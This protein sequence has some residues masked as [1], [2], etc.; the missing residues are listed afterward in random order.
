[1]IDSLLERANQL[2]KLKRYQDAV[3]ELKQVLSIEPNRAQALALL[4]I[5][6]A[7]QNNTREAINFIQQAV[8][9]EPDNDFFLYLYAFF[10]FKEDKL[11][12]SEK[13]IRNAIAFEPRNAEYFGLLAL[14][15]IN[16]KEWQ[17]ALD[18]ANQGLAVDP[19]NLTCLNARSTAFFK[20]DKKEEAYSTINEALSKD[21]YNEVTHT[22][23]GWGLLEKGDHKKALEHFREALKINPDFEYAKA[24]LVEGLKARYWFYRMFLKYAFWVGNMKGKGQWAV[25]IG[26][27]FGARILRGV[28]ENNAT[29]ALFITPVIYLYI[30][31]AISTWIIGPLSNLFLRLNV[32]GRFALTDEETQSSNFVG[33]SL[34]VGGFGG[35]LFLFTND[36]LYAMLL[37]YGLTMMIPLAS[38]FNPAKERSKQILVG[39]TI[40]IGLIGLG[41]IM[42]QAFSY[43]VGILGTIYIFGILAYQWIANAMIIR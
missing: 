5:C 40:L 8:S 30:L 4:S 9:K 17:Q 2:I 31:F 36:F 21:P 10:L 32:Y 14:I 6:E 16:Q 20:L 19:D 3:K 39:Y 41:A 27:Y 13:M 15:R 42:D 29:L 11:K 26:L 12:E 23:L 22:N 18:S 43:G 38:M 37:I 1:M 34:A 24:G 7:E 28:A 25:I 33:I 35:L